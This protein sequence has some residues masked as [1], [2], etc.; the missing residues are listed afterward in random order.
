M[1]N[2]EMIKPGANSMPRPKVLEDYTLKTMRVS[3][4]LVDRVNSLSD[5]SPSY[6]KI[7]FTA[8]TNEAIREKLDRL[9][10]RRPR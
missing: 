2:R 1:R 9:E 6:A 7:D 3:R 10:K 5:A 8:F 4:E